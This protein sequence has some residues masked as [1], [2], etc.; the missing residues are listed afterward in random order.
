M[1]GEKE[2]EEEVYNVVKTVF[3][4][5]DRLKQLHPAFKILTPKDMLKGLAAPMHP[6]AIRF[7]K[8]KGWL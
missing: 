3:D 4:N 8:E 5:L 1:T 6:G 7:Y 2:H